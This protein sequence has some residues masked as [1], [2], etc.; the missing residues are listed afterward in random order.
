[1]QPYDLLLS[2]GDSISI[3]DYAGGPGLG[4]CS[5]LFRNVDRRWPEF[6]GRDVV[7]H[8]RKCRFRMLA[9]D[10][11]TSL[12]VAQQIEHALDDLRRA[13]QPLITLT[14]GGNDF[15]QALTEGDAAAG[16]KIFE[17]RLE[18]MLAGIREVAPSATVLLGNV[19]DPSDGTGRLPSQR[20][21]FSFAYPAFEALNHTIAEQAAKVGAKL[22]D[23]HAWHLGHG[24]AHADPS[25]PHYHPNDPSGWYIYDIEPNA[26]GASEIRRCFWNALDAP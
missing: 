13:R 19:Y 9:E 3:D 5:L 17:R 6:R 4:A 21:D 20:V 24:A 11:A 12:Q 25:S 7:T 1:L 8:A 15:L 10:G 26:R 14:V 22:V 23:L 2:L 18:R 16:L